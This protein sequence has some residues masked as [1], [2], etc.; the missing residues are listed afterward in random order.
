M[1]YMNI[2]LRGVTGPTM[3][4]GIPCPTLILVDPG[5][6]VR[7]LPLIYKSAR[8]CLDYI[9]LLQN[10]SRGVRK[11]TLMIYPVAWV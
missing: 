10:Q 3:A 11:P 8:T 1:S 5:R 2:C 4:R 6:G 9:T 7:S